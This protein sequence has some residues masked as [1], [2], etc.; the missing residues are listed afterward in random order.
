MFKDHSEVNYYFSRRVWRGVLPGEVHGKSQRLEVSL[1]CLE[2]KCWCL[3]SSLHFAASVL[4]CLEHQ[5]NRACIIRGNIEVIK[6]AILVLL[7]LQYQCYQACTISGILFGNWEKNTWART[8]RSN[9]LSFHTYT[10]S[11]ISIYTPSHRFPHIHLTDF[12][13]QIIGIQSTGQETGVHVLKERKTGIPKVLALLRRG[14]DRLMAI[15]LP[16]FFLQ[17]SEPK[18]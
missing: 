15:I 3:I 14:S 10:Y 7:S 17:N 11:Q 2:V 5:C 4:S 6:V 16:I 12:K 1:L 9:S 8:S 13:T 18:S